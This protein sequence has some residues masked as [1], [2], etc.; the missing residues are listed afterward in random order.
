M[1]GLALARTRF[2]TEAKGNS[3]IAYWLHDRWWD[4]GLM[5]RGLMNWSDRLAKW[6]HVWN[7][8]RKEGRK[9]GRNWNEWMNEWMNGGWIINCLIDGF[10]SKNLCSSV[11]CR[12]PRAQSPSG[13]SRMSTRQTSADKTVRQ[14]ESTWRS[15]CTSFWEWLEP[16]TERSRWSW[17]TLG[18]LYQQVY[19]SYFLP[20]CWMIDRKTRK[21]END[22]QVLTN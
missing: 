22:C 18:C 17:P 19:H 20:H 16:A 15:V 21:L 2:D 11:E 3:E 14:K 7:E 4:W 13:T 10:C 5:C 12:C 6:L 9:E 8:W 1:K